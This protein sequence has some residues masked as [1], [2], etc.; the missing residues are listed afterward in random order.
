MSIRTRILAVHSIQAN[1]LGTAVSNNIVNVL[2]ANGKFL[3]IV[4]E[5]DSVAIIIDNI[6]N[7]YPSVSTNNNSRELD[8]Y[9]TIEVVESDSFDSSYL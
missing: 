8:D 5:N 6:L 3:R 2:L 4:A 9:F 1:M 7:F